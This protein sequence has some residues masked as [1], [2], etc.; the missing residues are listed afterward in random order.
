MIFELR[1]LEDLFIP[2]ISF[3]KCN[4]LLNVGVFY[5]IAVAL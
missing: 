2:A 4:Y 3:N 5:L 1:Y